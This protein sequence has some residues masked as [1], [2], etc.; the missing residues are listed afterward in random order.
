VASRV[1]YNACFLNG[2]LNGFLKYGFVQVVPAADAAVRIYRNFVSTTTNFKTGK[3]ELKNK[4]GIVHLI[5]KD[6]IDALFSQLLKSLLCCWDNLGKYNK[7][8]KQ[9][10]AKS[11]NYTFFLHK[12]NPAS[13]MMTSPSQSGM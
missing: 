9:F 12:K 2:I 3:I 7:L 5:F 10:Q 4:K 1:L 8:F 6:V 11:K 13:I